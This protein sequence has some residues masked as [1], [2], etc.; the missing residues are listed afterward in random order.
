MMSRLC[1][2]LG[3]GSSPVHLGRPCYSGAKKTVIKVSRP[4]TRLI[5]SK[6]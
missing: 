4:Y 6:W 5:T 2:I 3:R 1:H